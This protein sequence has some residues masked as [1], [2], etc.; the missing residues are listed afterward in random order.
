MYYLKLQSGYDMCYMFSHCI[1]FFGGI[2]IVSYWTICPI[3]TLTI[4]WSVGTCLVVEHLSLK[5]S[6]DLFIAINIQ[7]NGLS[8]AKST[9]CRERFLATGLTASA[10]VFR[11]NFLLSYRPSLI[12][13][14]WCSVSWLYEYIL[15][16]HI[17]CLVCCLLA[18]ICARS[19]SHGPWRHAPVSKAQ[20]KRKRFW[21]TQS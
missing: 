11:Y 14:L 9:V 5:S 19:L 10:E 12:L 2:F 20:K 18:H 16:E 8:V 4:G 7:G 15:D 1:Y 3:N 13:V 6:N 21:F 17:G